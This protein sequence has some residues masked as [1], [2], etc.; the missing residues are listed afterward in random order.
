MVVGGEITTTA[1][2][3]LE[4]LIRQVVVDVGYDSSRVGFDGN[5]CSVINM[6]GKRP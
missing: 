3:D 5:T 4:D 6:I 2:V 1:W